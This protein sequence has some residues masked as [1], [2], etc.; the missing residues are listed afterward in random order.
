ML[1]SPLDVRVVDL[2]LTAQTMTQSFVLEFHTAARQAIT[3]VAHHAVE[4]CCTLARL[5]TRDTCAPSSSILPSGP[6]ELPPLPVH[7]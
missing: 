6:A 4:G 3:Q 7:A 2:E 5:G 1:T